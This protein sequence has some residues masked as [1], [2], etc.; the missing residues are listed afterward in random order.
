M[1]LEKPLI[2]I[3]LLHYFFKDSVLRSTHL[4]YLKLWNPWN[5]PL[6]TA[7]ALDYVF[8]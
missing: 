4:Q 1:F 8:L 2:L 7:L 5:P 6:G 3:L